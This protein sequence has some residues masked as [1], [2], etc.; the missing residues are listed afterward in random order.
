MVKAFDSIAPNKPVK[1]VDGVQSFEDIAP[2]TP[3]GVVSRGSFVSMED[4]IHREQ[5]NLSLSMA[6][7]IPLEQLDAMENP[8]AKE[9][10]TTVQQARHIADRFSNQLFNA[11]VSPLVQGWAAPD[12]SLANDRAWE[13]GLEW[14]RKNGLKP[15]GRDEALVEDQVNDWTRQLLGDPAMR[16]EALKGEPKFELPEKVASFFDPRGVEEGEGFADA[17]VDGV[18]G[19]VG[20]VAEIA[21][22]K[23]K[24]PSVPMPV[25]MEVVSI[26]NGGKPGSGSAMYGAMGFVGNMFPAGSVIGKLGSGAA[27]GGVFAG[28]TA[29][30][31]GSTEEVIVNFGI[32][33][34]LGFLSITKSEWNS[35]KPK[36]KL[37][38]IRQT[39]R[40]IPQLENTPIKEIDTAIR[41]ALVKAEVEGIRKLGKKPVKP[42]DTEVAG[43]RKLGKKPD[44]TQKPLKPVGDGKEVINKHSRR[45]EERAVV[46][47]VIG[48]ADLSTLATHKVAEKM[49]QARKAIDIPNEEALQMLEGKKPVPDDLLVN[50]VY[51]AVKNR[52]MANNDIATFRR[53]RAQRFQ[54]ELTTRSAQ[55]IN[56]LANERKYDPAALMEDVAEARGFIPDKK[57]AK[58][59]VK[60]E[61]N[62][63]KTQV[64]LNKKVI[65][66]TIESVVKPKA[67]SVNINAKTFGSKNK[68]VTKTR[69]DAAMKRL[70]DTSKLFTGVDPKKLAD[71]LEVSAYYVEATARNLP[72]YTKAMVKQFG[73]KVRPH[74]KGLWEKSL[75]SLDLEAKKSSVT[76]LNAAFEKN[77]NLLN[78]HRHIRTLQEALIGRGFKTRQTLLKEMHR[79]LSEIDPSIT[80]RQAMDAMSKSGV[81]KQLDKSEIKTIRRDINQQ[82]LQ[83]SKLQNMKKGIAPPASGGETQPL[84]TEGRRLTRLVNEAKKKGGFESISPEKELKSTLASIKTRLKNRITDLDAQIKAGKKTIKTKKPQ[85]SDAETKKLTA[86]KDKLQKQFNDMFGKTK[87]TVKQREQMAVKAV[88]KSITELTRRIK[89]NDLAPATKTKLSTPELEVLRSEQKALREQLQL[90]R[91]VN[92][93]KK[94]PEEIALQTYKT[95]LATEA[96]KF[97]KMIA[98]G[99]FEKPT[100]KSVKLDKGAKDL[101]EMRDEAKRVVDTARHVQETGGEMSN[102]EITKANELSMNIKTTK[103]AFEA[104]PFDMNK[105]S[106]Q[107]KYAK[108]LQIEY[109]NAVLDFQEF[110]HVLDPAPNNWRSV[111][112][113]VLGTPRTMMTTIDLSF[114]FRQGWGSMATPEFWKGFREQFGFAFNEKNFRNLMAEIEGSPRLAMAKKA[115]LG[116]TDLGTELRL[117]PEGIQSTIPERIPALGKVI[118]GSERAYTG[119]SNYIR[120]NRWNNMVDAYVLKG[121][122]L[123]GRQGEVAMRDIA[124]VINVMTGRGNLGLPKRDKRTGDITKVDPLGAISPEINMALF[125]ARKLSADISTMNPQWYI[126]QS[127]FARR[128]ALKQMIGSAGMT[129][130]ILKVAEMSGNE[131]EW[132]PTSS[133]FGKIHIGNRWID[134]T[135]G[136]ASMFTFLART[137]SGQIKGGEGDIEETTPF[138]RSRLFTRLSRGKLAP[139]ASLATDLYLGQDFLGDPVQTPKE[140]SEAVGKRFVTLSIADAIDLFGDDADGD[141]AT[142]IMWGIPFTMAAMF[143]HGVTVRK[144][145]ELDTEGF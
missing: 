82:F 38:L 44:K 105:R 126:K 22:L 4:E 35:L 15:Y 40:A 70:G 41:K 122:T 29:I 31:G 81:F 87:L 96:I 33:A 43:I 49:K 16:D 61:K 1:A 65:D 18:A 51:V 64:K 104:E 50:S 102:A 12:S 7:G 26:S 54:S 52:A 113:D 46:E 78:S 137:L 110:T 75:A 140:I 48:E 120:W 28:T 118:K 116:L 90:M 85:P 128:M 119:M 73:E 30:A 129:A 79:I 131:I 14:A 84:S 27:V 25:L 71:V 125:S 133:N 32:P 55:E 83:V 69:K 86:E 89:E 66:S 68:I 138:K 8:A 112:V 45:L 10:R 72:A 67:K 108:E 139:M 103:A 130:G 74:L 144:D 124:N 53:L 93:P 19:I 3:Q 9:K 91:D 24:M 47:G 109:G 141:L 77:G 23:K 60:A 136:K 134:I 121:G 97:D 62:L 42:I 13:L 142:R 34:A 123:S 99:E 114:P 101:L 21:I 36:S 76:K 145:E 37:A 59:L 58:N 39:K 115:G 57:L 127:P 17:A 88:E 63:D 111:A 106:G 56:A 107:T 143:G 20:F 95:R 94:S 117:R 2:S 6:T 132:N 80:E 100:R 135:G 11:T 5:A 98:S 92:N